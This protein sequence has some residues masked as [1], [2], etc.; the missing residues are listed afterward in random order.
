M[1]ILAAAL[2]AAFQDPQLEAAIEATRPYEVPG[3]PCLARPRSWPEIGVAERRRQREVRSDS[4]WLN[5]FV[6]DHYGERL[7][8]SGLDATG[9]RLRHVVWL[10]GSAPI[11]PLR[12]THR[13]ANVPVEIRYG[14]PWSEQ[15]VMRRRSAAGPQRARLVPDAQGEGFVQGPDAGWISLDVYSPDGGPRADVL[16]HCQALRRAYR[17]PVLIRFI[18]GRVTQG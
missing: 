4:H 6:R 14:A 11:R 12:L 10:T 17:L 15:E 16:A 1:F 7:A 9:G 2:S 8:F 18:A 5:R 13:A 3:R